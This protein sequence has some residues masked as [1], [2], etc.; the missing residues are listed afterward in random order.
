MESQEKQMALSHLESMEVVAGL[1]QFE[2][3]YRGIEP[4]LQTSRKSDNTEPIHPAVDGTMDTVYA[5]IIYDR[6]EP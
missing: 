2:S 4:Q 1:P 3:V 5:W 6:S